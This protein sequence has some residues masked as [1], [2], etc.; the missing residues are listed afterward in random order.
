MRIVHVT[1]VYLPQVGGIEIF[2]DDLARRQA[3]AGHEV[4][5]LTQ[6]PE[7]VRATVESP[8][9]LIRA[10]Q[11]D[12]S[13]LRFLA[14][15]RDIRLGDFDVVHAHLSVVSPFSTLVAQAAVKAGIPTLNTV[16]SIWSGRLGLVRGVG[17]LAGW[18]RWPV[19]WTAVSAAAA[20]DVRRVLP[21]GSAVHVV[22]NAVDVS[23]W[24]DSG[25]ATAAMRG[26]LDPV[27]LISVMRLA[28][29]KRP[30][31]LLRMLRRMRDEVP[32]A[33]PVRAVIVGEGPHETRMRAELARHGMDDWVSMPGRLSRAELR[34]LY[35][36]ADFY[37]APAYRESFGIAALEA[38]SVGLPVV[39][40]RSGG[41]GEFVRHGVEGLLCHDDQDMSLALVALVTEPALREEMS[42]H[43]A[44]VAPHHDWETALA[45]FE[46]AYTLAAQMQRAARAR[47]ARRLIVAGVLD[48][49]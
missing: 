46:S 18:N 47:N 11:S 36:A 16:H 12:P 27:T 32:D 30:L 48:D 3:A 14:G 42:F 22:P 6:T 21:A 19:V 20:T 28:G 1:D 24:R 23:W 29:R 31:P 26:P 25:R 15:R 9:H 39:A 4:T 43:N 7:E 41:V 45:A 33:V 35:R 5:V 2:V 44:T 17:A 40:M 38:R 49:R 37:V 8:V 13:A 10:G 34:D